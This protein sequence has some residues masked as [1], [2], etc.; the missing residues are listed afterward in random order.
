MQNENITRKKRSVVLIN[1]LQ[2]LTI[3]LISFITVRNSSCG[4][5]MFSQA[6]VK[7]SVHRADT[8]PPGR[9]IPGQT[10]PPPPQADTPLP[11][12]MAT[13]A[14]GTHPNEMHSGAFIISFIPA[15]IVHFI[16]FSFFPKI[17]VYTWS[18]KGPLIPLFCTSGDV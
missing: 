11:P 10:P 16:F 14:D 9:H 2:T 13:A 17:L 8:H 12:K 5:V 4:K 18:F 3:N 6:C 15:S 7:N 1:C